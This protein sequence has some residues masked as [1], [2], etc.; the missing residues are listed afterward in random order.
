[1]RNWLDGRSQRV[2][3]NNLMSTWM[4]GRSAIPQGAVLGPVRFNIFIN[5]IDSEIECTLNKFA[6]DTELSGAADMPKG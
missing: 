5:N 6:D 4:P 1:M 2:V 3:V